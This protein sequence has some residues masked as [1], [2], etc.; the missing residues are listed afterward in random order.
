MS[1]DFPLPAWEMV[2]FYLA[3]AAAA[4]FPVLSVGFPP[5]ADLPNHLA[6]VH[7]MDNLAADPDLARHYALQWQLL[8]F[9]SSDLILPPLAKLVGLEPAARIFIV[10]T[11]AALLG[12]TFALHK[13]LFGRV[14]LWPALAFLLLYNFMFAWGLLSFLFTAGLALLLLAAW[15]HTA[16]REGVPRSAGFA[17]GALV[18]FFFH[19]L[20]F[21]FFAWA[22][23][24]FELWRWWRDRKQL[25]RRMILS[26]AVF[27]IPAA[28]FLLAPRSTIP[29]LNAYG[30]V[31]DKVRAIL[32]PFNM[33]FGWPDLLLA[34]CAFV[35]AVVCILTRMCQVAVPIR[36]PLLAVVAAALLMPNHLMSVWGSDFRLPTIAL[37]LLIGATDVRW[38]KRW[39]AAVFAASVAALMLARVGTV[40]ADWRRMAADIA[41]L[42][43]ALTVLDRS[44]KVVVMESTLDGRDPP[45]ASLYPYR[46]LAAFAVIDR[47]VF[48]PHLFSAATP[49]RFVSPGGNWTTEQLAV[50]RNPEWHPEKP[51]ASAAEYKTKLAVRKVT[52]AIQEFDLA[53]STVDWTDWPERFDYLI[54]FDYGRGENPVPALLTELHRGSYFTIFRIHSP[55]P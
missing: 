9:Q 52:Q 39:Q 7:I 50:V 6:R 49:L 47:N 11:F 13:V 46:H 27:I 20:A 42:R 4:L 41:E 22:V 18:L 8:A 45:A 29:V 38:K 3:L 36:W 10:A 24:A 26:G 17:F 19:F 15:I 30:E 34:F 53:T 33:Y 14:G 2:V 55:A 1:Y 32:S 48:L 25:V 37:L 21:A 54:D 12:G 16:E 35:L 44:S 23:L 31:I 40:T 43:A 51:A 28:L 5:L